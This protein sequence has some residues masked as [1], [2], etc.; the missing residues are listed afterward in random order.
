MFIFNI[1]EVQICVSLC[2]HP[3]VK[4]AENDAAAYTPCLGPHRKLIMTAILQELSPTY[5]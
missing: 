1:T 2:K 4:I 5:L 3:D